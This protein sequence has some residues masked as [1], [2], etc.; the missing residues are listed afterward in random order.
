MNVLRRHVPS[1]TSSISTLDPR[2]PAYGYTARMF[3]RMRLFLLWAVMLAIPFQ[4]YAAATMAF[5]ASSSST[6]SQAQVLQVARGAPDALAVH[7]HGQTDPTLSAHEHDSHTNSTDDDAGH[8][9]GT[10]GACHS[11]ALTS[12]LHPPALF[13]LP[14]ADLQEPVH[15][16][17]NVE[18][19]LLDKP[20]RA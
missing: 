5:C 6:M 9:C 1:C 11:S 8:K 17:R 13:T 19:R 16:V 7:D 12:V 18:P 14:Q 3:S 4:G 10:C 20:P 15:V 2:L